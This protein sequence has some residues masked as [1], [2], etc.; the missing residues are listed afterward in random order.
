MGS[1]EA[2]TQ[3][4]Y[5]KFSPL[6]NCSILRCMG[7]ASFFPGF[8]RETIIMTSCLLIWRKKSSRNWAYF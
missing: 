4:L 6:L 7:T 5:Q 8:Q 2:D 1:Y 3:D